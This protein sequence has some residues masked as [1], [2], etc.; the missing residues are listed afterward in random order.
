[1]NP[2]KLSVA[3]ARRAESVGAE[4]LL[5]GWVRT[6]RDSKAGFSFLEINDGSCFGNIQVI[7]DG[8]AAELR[9]GNQTAHASVAASASKA[10]SRPRRARARRPRSQARSV[11]VHGWSDA[12][13]FP[14]AE[15]GAHASSSSARSPICGRGR[16]PSAPS[17]ACGTASAARSTTSSRKK[18]SS[19]STRRSSRPATAKGPGPCSRSPRSTWQTCRDR[20]RAGRSISRRTSSTGRL[21]DR[22]RAA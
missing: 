15:E 19:T 12:E 7:A 18:A 17:P 1:M 8:R 10:W 21:S 20:R 13:T 22:Q 11:T 16:T 14:I 3:Q 4:V 6:R 5:Q 2:T 9:D